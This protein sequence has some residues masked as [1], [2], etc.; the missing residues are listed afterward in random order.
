MWNSKCRMAWSQYTHLIHNHNLSGTDY[1]YLAFCIN[2]MWTSDTLPYN[3]W[4]CYV[5]QLMMPGCQCISLSTI[6]ATTKLLGVQ[7]GRRSNSC[8][9]VTRR[10]GA[11]PGR[12]K[13]IGAVIRNLFRVATLMDIWRH[14][15]SLW[16][17]C[18]LQFCQWSSMS[19]WHNVISPA[20]TQPQRCTSLLLEKS[21]RK[22]MTQAI[23]SHMKQSCH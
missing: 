23:R 15:L 14:H 5:T 7:S 1:S 3:L 6:T 8:L 13:V 12:K 11:S 16:Q 4:H 10:R 20:T 18:A 2:K 22:T 19:T 17:F 9:Y 21:S